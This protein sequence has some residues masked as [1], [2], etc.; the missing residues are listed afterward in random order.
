LFETCKDLPYIVVFFHFPKP[1]IYI[2]SGLVNVTHKSQLHALLYSVI[3][4]KANGVYP[5]MARFGG[6]TQMTQ[7]ALNSVCN[8]KREVLIKEKSESFRRT[9]VAPGVW[10]GLITSC[11]TEDYGLSD[12][13]DNVDV[14]IS[15]VIMRRMKYENPNASAAFERSVMIERDVLVIDRHRRVSSS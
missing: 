1:D 14:Q 6:F 8:R 15:L 9:R 4:I 12:L 3:L 10:N 11:F 7:H 5:E 13:V 2:R